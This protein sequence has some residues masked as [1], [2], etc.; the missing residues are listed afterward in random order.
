M[1]HG[2]SKCIVVDGLL[3]EAMLCQISY[4]LW[5]YCVEIMTICYNN[6]SINTLK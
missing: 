5:G 6:I 3:W 2:F 4:Y 1:Q